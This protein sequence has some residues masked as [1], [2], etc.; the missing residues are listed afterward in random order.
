MGMRPT[1]DHNAVQA[2]MRGGV[3]SL[4]SVSVVAPTASSMRRLGQAFA[5]VLR[6]KDVILLSGPLGAGKTTFAQGI[7]RGLGL[8]GPVVSPTFTIAR[9]LHG[10]FAGGEPVRVVHVDAYRIGG[11]MHAPGS[12]AA[13]ALMDELE[14]LGL[15]EE[16]DDPSEGTIVLMEWGEHMA[17]I[18]SS[19]RVEVR[20]DRAKGLGGRPADESSETE[21]SAD[22]DR[23]VTFTAHGTS[24]AR[25]MGALGRALGKS[26]EEGTRDE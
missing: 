8:D 10:H 7:G 1:E 22:G 13:S 5:S 16:L 11:V 15:D 14:S 23:T 12:D 25:R 18:L 19:E 3:P 4:P 9:E 24:W 2:G 6:A 21:L 26:E 20:I 17:G